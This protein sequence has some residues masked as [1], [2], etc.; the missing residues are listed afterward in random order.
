MVP[1]AADAAPPEEVAGADLHRP[2]AA[3]QAHT[4]H[5]AGPR[6]QG[7]HRETGEVYIA[8][9]VHT[10]HNELYYIALY[11]CVVVRGEMGRDRGQAGGDLPGA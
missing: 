2:A 10:R 9:T 8:S 5:G 11:N 7:G 1:T 3:R 4:H 6:N